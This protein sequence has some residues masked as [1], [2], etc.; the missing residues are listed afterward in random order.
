MTVGHETLI[1]DLGEGLLRFDI[2]ASS[3]CQQ[4]VRAIV[5]T[6]VDMGLG[7]RTPG[8][9]RVSGLQGPAP[10][11]IQTLPT[12]LQYARYPAESSQRVLAH[13]YSRAPATMR[14]SGATCHTVTG[15]S[16]P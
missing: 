13:W 10:V 2:T 5:G 3:F 14:Y 12:T 1:R 8:D 9:M 15:R 6:L 16:K 4:M 7:K 11:L